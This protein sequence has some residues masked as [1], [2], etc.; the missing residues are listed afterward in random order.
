MELTRNMKIALG[1]AGAAII[2]TAAYFLFRGK[3]SDITVQYGSSVD[4]ETAKMLAKGLKA[5]ELVGVIDARMI[6][7]P[8]VVVG[9]QEANPTWAQLVGLG[10]FPSITAAY[11]NDGL[12]YVTSYKGLKVVGVA[13]WTKA[14]TDA[15]AQYLAK[16][17]NLPDKT[18]VI[19][20]GV[21]ASC[22]GCKA[23][24]YTEWK[25]P[26]FTGEVD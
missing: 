24:P 4:F 22:V 25:Q 1:A 7:E 19:K 16:L 3:K 23:L 2:G 13:G 10:L 11:T 17:G 15:A 18:L 20:A 21:V 12:I 8:L 9:A 14:A 6:T 26:V 5:K